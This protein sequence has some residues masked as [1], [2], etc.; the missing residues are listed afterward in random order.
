M[1]GLTIQRF[2]GEQAFTYIDKLA[3]LRIKVF[4]E[5]PYLYDGKLEYEKKYLSTY[6]NCPES[7]L[8]IVKDKEEVVGVSSAIPL[9]FETSECQ[10][11][12]I[13]SQLPI[14]SIFYFG[15]SVLLPQYRGTGVYRSFFHERENAARNYGS[16]MAAFCAV[17]RDEN[18]P[19]RPND[20]TTLATIW[21]HFGYKQHPEL[22]AYYEW[23]E[24]DSDKSTRKPMI[25][26]TKD[27]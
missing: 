9:E 5:Y 1:S 3:E 12:F 23:K 21:Q 4:K 11:P 22:R 25:F 24:I 16:H 17:E 7:I 2:K 13:D 14:N 8:V 27:L 15:E 19:R 20:Y 18:D 26:W 10:Q 6:T